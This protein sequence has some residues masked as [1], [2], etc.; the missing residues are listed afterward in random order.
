[1]T[2]VNAAFQA[3]EDGLASLEGVSS[4]S[5]ALLAERATVAFDPTLWTPAKLA[6]EIED[7]GFEASPIEQESK[8]GQTTVS[9]YGMTCASFVSRSFRR[10]WS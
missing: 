1:L 2:P 6:S 3:I 9:I 4:V 5:V 10:G 8:P 7:L